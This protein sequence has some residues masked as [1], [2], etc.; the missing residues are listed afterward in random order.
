MYLLKNPQCYNVNEGL[1]HVISANLRWWY[2][3]FRHCHR[4]FEYVPLNG[5]FAFMTISPSHNKGVSERE[6]VW[7]MCYP[8]KKVVSRILDTVHRSDSLKVVVI[9]R[10]TI[11]TLIS[12]SPIHSSPWDEGRLD[13]IDTVKVFSDFEVVPGNRRD[14]FTPNK[15]N[16][17]T[18][19][20][21]CNNVGSLPRAA[22]LAVSKRISSSGLDLNHYNY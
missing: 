7:Y 13:Y 15:K 6:Q 2:N 11:L 9:C 8:D 12:R 22:F 14:G 4:Q 21:P 20:A 19:Y 10:S 16:S 5:A 1:V 17:G 18:S 3:K